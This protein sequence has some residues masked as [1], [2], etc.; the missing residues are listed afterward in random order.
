[1]SYQKY[2]DQVKY[3]IAKT[4][5]PNLYPELSIP[6]STA[7]YWIKTYSNRNVLRT[8][9][10]DLFLKLKKLE[11][12]NK[13]LR[14][15]LNQYKKINGTFKS[16]LRIYNI[17]FSSKK[18]LSREEKCRVLS[19]IKK[20]SNRIGIR[21]L[22]NEIGFSYSKYKRL[23][24]ELENKNH[25]D[26]TQY[27]Q[28]HPRALSHGEFKTLASLYESPNL[29]HLPLGALHYY[30]KREK[31]VYCSP[32]TWSK[33]SKLFGL[34]R[35]TNIKKIKKYPIGVRAQRPNEIWHIDISVIKLFRGKKYYLQ[36]IIDNYSRYLIGFT[37]LDTK[38][39]DKTYDLIQKCLLVHGIPETVFMDAGK[40]NTSNDVQ[41]LL[42]SNS[43]KSR[44]YL[45]TTR[46]S[47]STIEVFFRS[48]K[49]NYLRYKR[50]RKFSELNDLVSKY[51][52]D[53]NQIIP[54]SALSGLVPKE[55]YNGLDI[56]HYKSQ[57][58]SEW[59]GVVQ[60]RNEDYWK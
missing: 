46:Y 58:K 42:K 29:F 39:A 17:N 21:F 35:P 16:L 15:E 27:F 20:N 43:I 4:K 10:D 22:L 11:I 12:K 19:I 33:Y 48:L 51:I 44:I 41:Y 8:E 1:M 49:M 59:K 45:K 30:A 25:Q 18:Q 7:L 60:A 5:N 28:K 26:R 14:S 52:S 9:Q 55:A 53:Y 36:A 56:D 23:K 50:Y 54:H 2:P 34:K 13:V 6:R 24:K 37:L 32:A 38:T 31:L 3:S 47:N 40:E 57:F